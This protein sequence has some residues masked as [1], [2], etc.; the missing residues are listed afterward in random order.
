MRGGQ[1]ILITDGFMPPADFFSALHVLMQR[2]LEIKVLQVLTSQEL[3]PARL[4]RGGLLVD[5]ETGATH[6]LAYSPAE[7]DRAVAAHNE[8]LVRFCKLHGIAFAEA[9]TVFYDE[10]ALLVDDP[11][12]SGN[13]DRF[14]MLGLSSSLRMLIVC[15]CYHE[16][17]EVIR[18][19]SAR[20]AT[21]HETT[22]GAL[23]DC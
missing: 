10:N 16:R 20:K 22:S 14:I 15:H 19:F 7:L 13:E 18:I 3:H 6:Q 4:F 1:A 8:Q 5:S 9:K 21:L 11:D 17:D 23:G 12:H 2:N